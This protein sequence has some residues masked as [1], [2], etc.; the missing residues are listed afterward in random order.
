MS[1]KNSHSKIIFLRRTKMKIIKKY[2]LVLVIFITLLILTMVIKSLSVTSKQVKAEPADKF[3]VDKNSAANHLAGAVKIETIS[4]EDNSKIK[5]NNFLSFHKY[6][7]STYPRAHAVLSKEVINNY[8]L[9][10]KWKGTDDNLKPMLLMAH[11]DVVPA[12]EKTIK[13]WAYPPF[14]GKIAD[15]F[16]WGRGTLDMKNS[17]IGIMEAVEG[18]IQKG[19]QPKRT[20]YIA[21]GHDEELGGINGNIKV[22]ELLKSRNVKLEYVIDEGS[23]ITQNMVPGIKNNVALVGISEKGYMNAELTAKGEAGHSS[24]PPKVTTVGILCNAVAKVEKNQCDAK[25]AGPVK[26]FLIYCAPEMSFLYRAIF[27]N[28]WIT[29]GLVKSIFSNSKT[30]NALIR[31]TTAPTML[32]GSDKSNVMPSVAKAVINFRIIP[33]DTTD[34]VL[35][36][37]QN[38]ITDQRVTVKA[39]DNE[40]RNPSPVSNVDSKNFAT[41]QK[42][43][44]QIFPDTIV[45]PSL[46]VAGTDS[47]HYS[48]LSNDIYRFLPAIM[49]SKDTVRLHGIDERISIDN[50]ESIIRFYM[51]LIQNSQS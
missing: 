41:L 8:S 49:T 43:I 22:A 46:V 34:S 23:V 44:R 2:L 42:S 6:L 39:R 10:Y 3:I 18:M 40:S 17:L 37:V 19:F 50:F 7:G 13:E 36:H 5:T 1:D 27:A 16:I 47:R 11:M 28:L 31:T 48:E 21:V 29:D 4:Y 30:M 24:M 38:T 14:D 12:N 20:I 35:K 33:G 25:I 51:Q 32:E 15:G 26:E 45:A 9:L